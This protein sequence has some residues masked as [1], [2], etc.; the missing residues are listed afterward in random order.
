MAQINGKEVGPS[1]S[2]I[3][4]GVVDIFKES[5]RGD[6]IEIEIELGEEKFLKKENLVILEDLL[7]RLGIKKNSFS[8]DSPVDGKILMKII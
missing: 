2:G 5:I 3:A 8:M 6:R 1:L 7:F 4:H